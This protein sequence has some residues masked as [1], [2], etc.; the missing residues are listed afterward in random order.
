M[1]VRALFPA[2]SSFDASPRAQR[3]EGAAR[4]LARDFPSTPQTLD[5]KGISM[6][7]SER[8]TKQVEAANAGGKTF[9][10]RFA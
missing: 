10:R 9:V 3:R 1:V 7:I 4:R 5:K 6:A 2:L 8:E